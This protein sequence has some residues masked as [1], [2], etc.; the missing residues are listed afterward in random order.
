MVAFTG[1]VVLDP[2]SDNWTRTIY[3]NN[4]RLESTGARWVEST[5]IVSDTKTR[6]KT[7][8]S[9]GGTFTRTSTSR[10]GR[11]TYTKTQRL[12]KKTSSTQVT[13]RIEK[14]FTNTLVG[15][16]EEKSYVESTKISSIVDPVSYTHLTLL[17]TLVV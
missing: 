17:T 6:G 11:T 16:S 9:R 13:R 1:Q 5:N 15:P 10:S 4:I 7:T 14:S 12:R 3:V 2:P 8:V